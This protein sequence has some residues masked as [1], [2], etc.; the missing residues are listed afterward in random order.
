[1]LCLYG[2][3]FFF[4]FQAE[5]GIR[6]SSVTGVQTCASDLSREE[7][8]PQLGAPMSERRCPKCGTVY[9]NTARFCPRDGNM[10]VDVQA[11]PASPAPGPSASPGGSG[12][13]VRTPKPSPPPL[14]RASAMSEQILHARYQVQK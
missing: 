2:T 7:R 10:L 13:A 8:R 3:V 12:T 11:K 4:F 9:T 6:D 5:D 14:D 1:M